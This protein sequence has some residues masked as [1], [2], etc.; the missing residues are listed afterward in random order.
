ML[1]HAMHWIAVV[2]IYVALLAANIYE[3]KNL[4]DHF[5]SQRKAALSNSNSETT[6]N[7]PAVHASSFSRSV[8]LSIGL[9][10]LTV[11]SVIFWEFVWN[12]PG[13]ILV[14]LGVAGENLW[15]E[16][17]TDG[18]KAMYRWSANMLILGLVV[19][20]FE[21]VQLD[22]KLTEAKMAAATANERAEEL[23]KANLALERGVQ[24]RWMQF[25]S[26][27]FRER[28]R[29]ARARMDVELLFQEGDVD[30]YMWLT[31][32]AACLKLEGW[33]TSGPRPVREDDVVLL[34]DNKDTPM[35]IRAGAQPGNI[36]YIRKTLPEHLAFDEPGGVLTG[37]F[38]SGR[39]QEGGGQVSGVFMGSHDPRMP[40][41]L[42]KIIVAPKAAD[43]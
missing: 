30:G 13:V 31:G 37:A 36:A 33:K 12:H 18:M 1:H 24:P 20:M 26:V 14:L 29:K 21:A 2:A 25:N 19:E 23:R 34:D 43:W 8:S 28:L 16:K 10:A 6:N 3:G 41:N 4:A 7:I 27:K 32:V 15:D 5:L 38:I 22:G 17:T 39:A 11:A 9:L 42:I 40:E 35:A